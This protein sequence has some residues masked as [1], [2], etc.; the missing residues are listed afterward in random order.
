VK[1]FVYTPFYP[2]Q[3]QAAAVRSYW[4]IK[5]LKDARHEV[6]V[7]SSIK[8]DD[9]KK[10]IFNP[11][12]NKQ[13][14]LKRLFFEI[15]AGVELFFRIFFSNKDLYILSSPPFITILIASLGCFLKK[16]KYIIDVR[17]IYPDIYFAQ[18]LIREK[19]LLAILIKK[20]TSFM[21][22]HAHVT[23]SVTPGLVKKI[24]NLSPTSKVELLINGYD[25]DLF[26]PC[27]EKFKNFTVIFHGNMGQVQNIPIILEVAKLLENENVDFHFIGEGPQAQLFKGEL[28]QNVKYLGSKDYKEIPSYISKAHIGFSARRDDEIGADAFPVKV[29]EYLG[30]GIPIIMT[31]PSKVMPT[32]VHSGIYEFENS[33]IKEMADKI[34]E[35]KKSGERVVLKDN[36][37]R[38]D[39]SKKI[40]KF[41]HLN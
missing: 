35:L 41:C 33:Q 13:T 10:L 39:V 36:L 15:L 19:S 11:A 27:D 40:L 16:K 6:N 20:V 18:G 29:F 8:T 21:Y 38:Q 32:M 12:D 3:P 22:S 26:K 28:T 30:V 4:I 31:P 9:S 17:D 14:F 34:L 1:I 7:Y 24:K 37:S 2:P 23:L 25:R 5:A